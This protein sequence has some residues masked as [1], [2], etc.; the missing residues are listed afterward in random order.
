VESR[1]LTFAKLHFIVLILG[2]TAI[3]GKLISVD[4]TELVW[5]RTL[6]AGISAWIVLKIRGTH[7]RFPFRS[8]GMLLLTGLIVGAHWI[9]FFHAIKVSNV[10]VALACF[11]STTLFTAF[12]EPLSQGRKISWVEVLIGGIIILGINTIFQFETRYAE[13]IIYAVVSAFLASMFSVINKNISL[14]YSP[15]AI[16]FYEMTGAFAGISVFALCS[17]QLAVF[18]LDISVN[19][20]MYLLILALFCTTYAFTATVELMKKLSAYTVVLSINLEP[21]YGII[22]AFFIFGESEYMSE[23]FYIGTTILISSV[24][25]YYAYQI[26]QKK[27]SNKRL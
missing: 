25:G 24:F 27:R 22:M 15:L 3:L 9:T 11:S 16:N 7:L 1:N 4:A 12:I 13:G 8:I 17:S 23:G 20:W 21:V 5:Y 2:F 10:S 18:E 19:D 26:N 14:K 6:L